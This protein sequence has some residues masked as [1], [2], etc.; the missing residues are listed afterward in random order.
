MTWAIG[1]AITEIGGKRIHTFLASG[2]LTVIVG[3]QVEYLVVGGGGG[4]GQSSELARSGGGG[5]AGGFRTATGFVVSTSDI[6]VTVG[7]AVD[8]HVQGND[9]IFSS[10]TSLGGGRGGSGGGAEAGAVGG[11]GGGGGAQFG[12]GGAGTG[13]QGC[14]GAGASGWFAGGGGGAGHAGYG[15]AGPGGEGLSSSISGA[16]VVYAGGGGGGDDAGNI[17][18]VGGGGNGAQN[19]LY[20][21]AGTN[22]L[23]GGGGG[24]HSPT[25]TGAGGGS[26]IVIISYVPTPPAS[27]ILHYLL[28][29]NDPQQLIRDQFDREVPPEELRPNK[30]LAIVGWQSPTA[31]VPADFIDDPEKVPISSV[32]FT[33]PDDYS[34]GSGTDDL[35]D[36]VLARL[37]QRSA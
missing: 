22:G 7:A 21:T 24:A 34:L 6:V 26:G 12:A 1:G 28:D 32:R 14:A 19:G 11:S 33:E 13:G 8:V 36:S 25:Y 37:T 31:L 5:G 29:V 18:G 4:G 23:G 16:A 3:G 15:G 9:S 27:R 2:T 10:I 20:A 35:L 17:G 30:W